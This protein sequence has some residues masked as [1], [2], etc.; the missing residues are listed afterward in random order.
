MATWLVLWPGL[1]MMVHDGTPVGS[2]W[3]SK[4]RSGSEGIARKFRKIQRVK[5][6]YDRDFLTNVQAP[7]DVFNMHPPEETLD[8]YRLGGLANHELRLVSNHLQWCDGCRRIVVDA[9]ELAHLIRCVN[10]RHSVTEYVSESTS[11]PPN[12]PSSLPAG[13][14]SSNTSGS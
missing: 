8:L 9:Q 4:P 13:P 14:L 6:A 1:L 10:E 7:A 11:L 5:L 3:Q 2:G 12:A